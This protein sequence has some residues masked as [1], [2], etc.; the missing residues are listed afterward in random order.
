M[1]QDVIEHLTAMLAFNYLEKFTLELQLA[2]QLKDADDEQIAETAKKLTDK[3]THLCHK[4]GYTAEQ[5]MHSL[6]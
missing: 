5:V 3:I 1:N 2:E 4:S 6:R